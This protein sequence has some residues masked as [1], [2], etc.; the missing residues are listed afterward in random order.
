M[1]TPPQPLKKIDLT[2]SVAGEEDPGSSIDLVSPVTGSVPP[3]P[4]GPQ[5]PAS[6]MDEAPDG[7]PRP[8]DS[9]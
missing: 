4:V 3:Q 7:K 6:G 2:E 8:Q 9:A 5:A 1:P